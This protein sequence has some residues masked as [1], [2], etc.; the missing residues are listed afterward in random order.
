MSLLQE[1]GQGQELVTAPLTDQTILP[2]ITR[3]SVLQLARSWDQ[4]EVSERH[5]TL[6]ELAQVRSTV[7]N[8]ACH[9]KYRMA[10]RI[11]NSARSHLH[12]I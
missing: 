7:T 11:A 3:D 8:S 6:R 12:E 10:G 5:M 4:F 9:E 2:G 1:G